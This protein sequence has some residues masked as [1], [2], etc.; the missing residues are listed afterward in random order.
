MNHKDK[1]K[2]VDKKQEE[3]ILLFKK[4]GQDIQGLDYHRYKKYELLCKKN[5]T[6]HPNLDIQEVFQVVLKNL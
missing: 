2:E 3:I 6:R 1:F 5:L 4:L